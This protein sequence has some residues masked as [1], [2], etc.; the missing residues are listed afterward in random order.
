[1]DQKIIELIRIQRVVYKLIN[2]LMF[3]SIDI[4]IRNALSVYFI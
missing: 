2:Y 1:M 4:Q 3:W